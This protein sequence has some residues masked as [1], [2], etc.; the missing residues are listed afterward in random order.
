MTD[1]DPIVSFRNVSKSFGPLNVLVDL[2]LDLKRGD[3][4]VVLGPSGTGKSVLLKHI[5]RLLR[6]D[7]GQV[8]F[9]G[10]DVNAMT[11]NE[12][13][14]L[15]TRV[16]FLFQMSALF[17][18]LTVAQ[19][20]GFPL[21][22]HT[23]FS[24]SEKAD[25][26]EDAL[27]AV[28]LPGVGGKMPAALSGGQKKRVALARAIVLRPSL[29]LYDEPTTGLDPIRADLINELILALGHGA[30]VSSIVVTHDMASARKVA[31]RLVLLYDGRVVADGSAETFE[32]SQDDRVQRFIHGQADAEDIEAIRA[33]RPPDPDATADGVT[34]N[35]ATHAQP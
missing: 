22:Q 29:I 12:L 34:P 32:Q 18:S 2:S 21:D 31:D 3:T 33:Y 15:R 14:E 13:I 9:D 1:A 16:G 8:L 17:D 11:R 24:R 23:T 20:V 4:T 6:P 30:H 27:R 26:V 10:R 35:P 28:G 5:V 25:R 19:N 7:A